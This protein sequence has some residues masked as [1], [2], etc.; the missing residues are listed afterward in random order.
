GSSVHDGIDVSAPVGTPVRA[1]LRGDVVYSDALRGYGNVV[2]VRHDD[3]F[4]TVYAHNQRNLVT[5]GQRVDRGEIIARVGDSGHTTG[6]NLHFEVRKDN[7][8]RNPLFFLPVSAT[9]AVP[10]DRDG[11]GG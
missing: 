6:S 10:Q 9:V 5:A 2:I 7:I 1:A 3:G 11:H 4:A 8:A